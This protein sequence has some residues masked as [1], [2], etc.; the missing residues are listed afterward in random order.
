MG[1]GRDEGVN[2]A[3][4]AA[5]GAARQRSQMVL[6]TL[7]AGQFLMTLDSSVMNV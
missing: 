1:S 2:M 7:A 4:G 3:A 5:V 6:L